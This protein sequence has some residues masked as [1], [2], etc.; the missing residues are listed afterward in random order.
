MVD[1]VASI[2]LKARP[3]VK[4]ELNYETGRKLGRIVCTTHLMDW[5]LD[6]HLNSSTAVAAAFMGAGYNNFAVALE[7][8][9]FT[10]GEPSNAANN[11]WISD[12]GKLYTEWKFK[13]VTKKYQILN[14]YSTK[15]VHSSIVYP[16]V[17]SSRISFGIFKI[18]PENIFH[19]GIQL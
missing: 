14:Q 19:Y 13:Q 3:S 6:T 15:T 2:P 16:A 18:N 7:N 17:D 11:F 12:S 10:A 8:M 4:R 5:S 9:L 1:A